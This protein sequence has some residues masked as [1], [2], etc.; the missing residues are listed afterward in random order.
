MTTQAGTGYC[1]VQLNDLA[2]LSDAILLGDV[3]F[4]QYIITFDKINGQIGFN[5]N[6][7]VVPIEGGNSSFAVGEYVLFGFN[8]ILLLAITFLIFYLG[9]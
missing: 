3:L 2:T 8:I 4:N 9:A 1:Y 5:G 7:K 6:T